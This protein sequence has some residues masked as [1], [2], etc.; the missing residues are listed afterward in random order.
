MFLFS[1][2]SS[3]GLESSYEKCSFWDHCKENLSCTSPCYCKA[4]LKT[5]DSLP[6]PL[7][8]FIVFLVL[9]GV[10]SFHNVG[11]K[12]STVWWLVFFFNHPPH[13]T[14]LNILPTM[15]VACAHTAASLPLREEC[16]F[17]CCMSCTYLDFTN[18]A[19]WIAQLNFNHI[20]IHVWLR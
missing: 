17:N 7:H 10:F 14:F 16:N 5:W 9:K 18:K 13:P 3:L 1:H 11:E 4:T 20:L 6:C 2:T 12:R 19:T 15:R 8:T